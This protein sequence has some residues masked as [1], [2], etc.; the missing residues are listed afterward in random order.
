M[1]RVRW[2]WVLYQT[3]SPHPTMSRWEFYTG[4][5]CSLSR[6]VTR[7]LR[8]SAGFLVLFSLRK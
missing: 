7:S 3:V 2:T 8:F 1:E 6:A 4:R 5:A